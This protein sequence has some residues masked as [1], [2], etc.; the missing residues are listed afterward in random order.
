[1]AAPNLQAK[2]AMMTLLRCSENRLV[3]QGLPANHQIKIMQNYCQLP[4]AQLY[5]M[6]K[7]YRNLLFSVGEIPGKLLKITL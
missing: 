2:I 3:H 7:F 1:M 4:D 6:V 5:L